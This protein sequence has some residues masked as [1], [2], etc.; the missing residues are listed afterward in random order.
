MKR[1]LLQAILMLPAAFFCLSP[2]RSARA[3]VPVCVR[4]IGKGLRNPEGYRRLLIDELRLHLTHR[5]VAAGCETELTVEYVPLAD[6]GFLTGR[7]GSGI[8]QRL[9]VKTISEIPA[10]L[11]TLVQL[12]LRK[13]PIYMVKHLERSGL[14]RRT[15]Q[16][17][18]KHGHN[19][20]GIELVQL[21]IRT[22]HALSTLSGAAFRFR[23]AVDRWFLAARLSFTYNP[24]RVPDL[25]DDHVV[26]MF[27]EVGVEVGIT[28]LRDAVISPYLSGGLGVGWLQVFGRVDTPGGP[29]RDNLTLALFDSFLRLGVE[30]M[31]DSAV[32]LDFFGIVSLPFHKA[33][34]IDSRVIDAYTPSF[35]VG[36]AVAF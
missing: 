6:G 12:L 23:R 11:K 21:W 18:L 10:R 34:S 8:P 29:D 14:L 20:Y 35:G 17:L 15:G 13:E 33:R 24:A 26:R 5:V 7:F 2:L 30:M 4:F 36:C 22:P 25:P 1:R 9:P 19:F 32:R 16:S 3:T 27:G 31:R 28:L